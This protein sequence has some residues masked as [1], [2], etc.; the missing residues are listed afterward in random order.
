MAAFCAEVKPFLGDDDDER[1]G[2]AG[3][4]QPTEATPL[5]SPSTLW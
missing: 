2:K 5:T 1:V 3:V 4:G